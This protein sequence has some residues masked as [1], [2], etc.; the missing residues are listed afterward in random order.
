MEAEV[1]RGVYLVYAKSS[2]LSVVMS[3]FSTRRSGAGP[4]RLTNVT[5][6]AKPSP[7]CDSARLTDTCV[8]SNYKAEALSRHLYKT[9]PSD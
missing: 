2:G 3:M 5:D 9:R 7:V 8:V 6:H 1:R 4:R